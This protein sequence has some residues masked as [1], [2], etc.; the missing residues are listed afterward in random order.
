MLEILILLV[1]PAVPR[2]FQ[3]S[4]GGKQM[5]EPGNVAGPF[6]EGDDVTLMCAVRGGKFNSS[7]DVLLSYTTKFIQGQGSHLKSGLC[8]ALP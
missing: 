5:Q 6:N 7:H 3:V 1:P 2:I 4:S 8:R